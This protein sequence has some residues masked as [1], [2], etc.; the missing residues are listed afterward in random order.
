M[1]SDEYQLVSMSRTE[2]FTVWLLTVLIISVLT[3]F[4]FF[5]TWLLNLV[6]PDGQQVVPPMQEQYFNAEG[7]ID[8]QM[9]DNDYLPS[10]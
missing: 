8:D 7:I 1:P 9:I 6:S 5:V 10:N 3:F 4:I 2:K